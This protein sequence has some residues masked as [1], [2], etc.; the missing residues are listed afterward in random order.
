MK[1]LY[2]VYVLLKSFIA[3]Q[4]Q[5]HN[6]FHPSMSSKEA[7]SVGALEHIVLIATIQE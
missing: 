6:I 2:A 1:M 4:A 5:T 3:G 7:N